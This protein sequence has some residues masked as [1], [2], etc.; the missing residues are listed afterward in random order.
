MSAVW[1]SKIYVITITGRSFFMIVDDSFS[2]H[3]HGL[4]CATVKICYQVAM[5][6]VR[7]RWI[8]TQT[9]DTHVMWYHF[10]FHQKNFRGGVRIF[11]VIFIP[12]IRRIKITDWILEKRRSD[13]T[14][15]TKSCRNREMDDIRWWSM[16]DTAGRHAAGTEERRMIQDDHE[17]QTRS[18]SL[19]WKMVIW[20]NKWIEQEGGFEITLLT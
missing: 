19:F 4:Q 2:F 18:C 10:E 20:L 5:C 3:C 1:S 12:T 7:N 16:E 13:W 8:P 17:T 6:G 15:G 14:A 9:T 11:I